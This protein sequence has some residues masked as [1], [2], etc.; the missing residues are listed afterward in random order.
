MSANVAV[1]LS[2]CGVYDGSEIHEAVSVL[3]HLS[4][5]GASYH[6]FATDKPQARV[7][8]HLTGKPADEKRNVL[9]ESARIARGKIK[10][11]SALDASA[12]DA[13]I[14][15]GGFGAATN[16]CNFAD[17]GADCTIDKDAQRVVNAFHDAGKPVGMCCIAPV[18][19]ARVL[20]GSSVTIGSDSGTAD[21]I[22]RM[23]SKNVE[24]PVTEAL[25]DDDHNL[26]TSPAYMYGSASIH[27]VF[28]GIGQMVEQTLAR[29]AASAAR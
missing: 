15:P 7:V 5:A 27:Q 4:R 14:F 18:I 22:A 1:V 21:A 11:L 28:D 9:R 17:K 29:C 26:V 20:R 3:I 10:P 13:V 23:G 25:V 6:C 19:A 2:G 8:D 12:F 24:K 16:L